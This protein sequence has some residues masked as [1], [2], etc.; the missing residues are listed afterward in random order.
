[1][2]FQR[3]SNQDA[4]TIY[5]NAYWDPA[6]RYFVIFRSTDGANWDLVVRGNPVPVSAY[7]RTFFHRRTGTGTTMQLIDA[8]DLSSLDPLFP[9]Q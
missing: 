3:Y 9:S 6:T 7:V 5:F 2:E 1:M 4:T 8:V